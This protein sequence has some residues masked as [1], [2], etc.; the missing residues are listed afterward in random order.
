MKWILT[1]LLIFNTSFGF[2]GVYKKIKIKDVK[3]YLSQT[4]LETT[5]MDEYLQRRTQLI[6]KISLSP[7][8]LYVGTIASVFGSAFVGVNLARLTGL[9][10]LGGL[11]L[12]V[13]FGG[14]AGAV[15]IT[16]G[17]VLDAITLSDH[18]VLVKALTES[19]TGYGDYYI[20]KLYKTYLSKSK[21]DLPKEAFMNELLLAD[22]AGTLCDGTMVPPPVIRI[23]TK[24]KFKVAKMKQ[25]TNHF[26]QVAQ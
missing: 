14:V 12:G 9:D 25:V 10:P 15:G 21:V 13:F 23:G 19:Y 2:A 17:T 20:E 11:F 4:N 7:V 26:D 22:Q 5:C 8:S 16:T 18:T 6:V 1:F 3:N 24:L